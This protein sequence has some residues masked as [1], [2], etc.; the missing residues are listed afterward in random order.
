MNLSPYLR[1]TRLHQPTG[2]WLLFLPCLFGIFLAQKSAHLQMIE[3][4][5]IIF[6]FLVGSVVMRSAGCV[7]NDLFDQKFDALVARTK[8]RPL[9][10][11]ELSRQRAFILLDLLLLLGLVI[12]LQFNQQTIFSGFIALALVATYPLMKRITYYPQIF[13]GLT[14]NFGI[15]MSSLAMLGNIS[16]TTVLLYTASIIWTVIYDTIYAFQDIE[17]D[18]R[19]GVKSTA[20]KFKNQPK[21]ILG[22]LALM[23]LVILIILGFVADLSFGYFFVILLSCSAL[24]SQIQKYDL[25]TGAL[26]LFKSNVW[27]GVG[28]ALAVLLG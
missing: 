6:L 13:L 7:I 24:I 2:I 9:A 28:I 20:I 14:F 8:S 26:K 27:I 22:F 4:A 5:W 23:M 10:A 25:A 18:L 11:K 1:L 19:F 15:L 12:L 17:D 21:K 3:L 16:L